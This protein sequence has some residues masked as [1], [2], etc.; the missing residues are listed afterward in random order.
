MN[1][2]ILMVVVLLVGVFLFGCTSP[3]TTG[4]AFNQQQ[5]QQQPFVGGGCGVAPHA[6]YEDTPIEAVAPSDSAF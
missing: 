2:K 6:D 3:N 4:G 5:G 1:V